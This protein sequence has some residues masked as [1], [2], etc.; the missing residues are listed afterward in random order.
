M[1]KRERGEGEGDNNEE[2]AKVETVK[3]RVKDK[4]SSIQILPH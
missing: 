3:E 1:R 4:S 2:N